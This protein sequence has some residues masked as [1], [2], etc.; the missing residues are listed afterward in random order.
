MISRDVTFDE[1]SMLK[2][3]SPTNGG[4][5]IPVEK[6]NKASEIVVETEVTTP[7]NT[8]VTDLV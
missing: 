8:R 7:V 4:F 3:S 5:P 2:A 6:E 1:A